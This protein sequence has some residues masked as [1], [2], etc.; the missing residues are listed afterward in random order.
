MRSHRPSLLAFA[1][2]ALASGLI[3]LATVTFTPTTA[4]ACPGKEGACGAACP[5][6]TGGECPHAAAGSCA[7]KEAGA[8]AGKAEGACA[9]DCAGKAT[10]ECK[11]D[12]AG[13]AGAACTG[14]CAVKDKKACACPE[15][16]DGKCACGAECGGKHG[17]DCPAAAG[18]KKADAGGCTGPAGHEGAAH[19]RAVIDPET[20][21]LVTPDA[22]TADV[23]AAAA[24]ALSAGSPA[25]D[26]PKP[27]NMPGGGVSAPFPKERASHAVVKVNA[28]GE[29]HAGCEHGAE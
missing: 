27:I 29:A 4:D 24:A 23:P 13:K 3:A 11:G 7:G 19:Q 22:G 15:G 14:D 25:A 26:A 16:E 28:A 20:G 12:C 18:D 17:G 1:G 8:C 5:E 9:G 6:A 2:T 10:G 21:L